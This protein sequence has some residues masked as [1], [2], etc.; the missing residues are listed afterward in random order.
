MLIVFFACGDPAA[1]DTSSYSRFCE[2]NS[3]CVSVYLYDPCVGGS[4]DYNIAVMSIAG[5]ESF[6][7]DIDSEFCLRAD[8]PEP[9]QFA[10]GLSRPICEEEACSFV[11]AENPDHPSVERCPE[12]DPREMVPCFGVD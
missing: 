5:W 11:S 1:P 9:D 3:D 10:P 2:L 4:Y 7:T 12:T 6:K 8:L